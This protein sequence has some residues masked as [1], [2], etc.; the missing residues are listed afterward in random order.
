[1][2]RSAVKRFVRA[3]VVAALAL[4]GAS[5]YS[6][7]ALRLSSGRSGVI[8]LPEN[9]TTGFSWRID[10]DASQGLDLLAITDG[11]HKRGESRPGAPGTHRW[12]LRALNPG[13]ATI[14][15]DYQR[16]WEPAPVETRRIDVEITP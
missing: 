4:S 3:I 14:Q 12:T 2:W 1:M 9:I 8:E 5:A 7:E 6:A 13:R 11:G 15:F 16:P 10:R